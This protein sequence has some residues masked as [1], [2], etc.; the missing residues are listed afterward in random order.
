MTQ[1]RIQDFVNEANDLKEL[2]RLFPGREP[3][4][5]DWLDND[6]PCCTAD[7]RPVVIDDVD[8]SQVPNVV[9]GRV[10]YGDGKYADYKWN[11][12]GTCTVAADAMNRPV[13]ASTMDY[14]C[15]DEAK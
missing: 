2:K 11:D 7:G 9:T 1:K 4:D 12:D 15:K 6:K 5:S 14:L 10:D 8:I 3:V 13:Q